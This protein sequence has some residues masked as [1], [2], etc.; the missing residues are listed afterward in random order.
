[1]TSAS[2]AR[3]LRSALT[4]ACKPPGGPGSYVTPSR[5]SG[6]LPAFSSPVT[7]S[8]AARKCSPVGQ[9]PECPS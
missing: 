3:C 8:I 4:N 1:L 9:F 2:A 5:L 7:R 6:G